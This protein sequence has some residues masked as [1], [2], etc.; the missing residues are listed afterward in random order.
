MIG[1]QVNQEVACQR[2]K[3]TGRNLSHDPTCK[4]PLFT[5]LL[6]SMAADSPHR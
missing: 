5:G 2:T 4:H 3:D 1:L 6:L